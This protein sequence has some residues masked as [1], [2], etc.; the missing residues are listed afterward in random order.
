MTEIEEM[1]EEKNYRGPI[2]II[3]GLFLVFLML[4]WLIPHYGL[5][6]NPE[7]EYIPSLQE[8]NLK[9]LEIPKVSSNQIKDFIQVNTEI[10][11]VADKIVSISCRETNR[12]CNAKAIFYFVQ[13]NFNYLSDPLAFEYYKT[14]QESL[15]SSNGDCDDGSILLSSLLQSVGFRTR[16]VFVPEHVYVQVNIPEAISSYK[17]EN[18]WISLDSTCIGCKFGEISSG[19]GKSEKIYLE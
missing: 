19:F 17:D 10:K 7:P 3:S 5:K 18:D 9:N 11:Q 2:K 4:L 6:Q 12:V 14:P 13:K 16:F 1:V 15:H 8:I